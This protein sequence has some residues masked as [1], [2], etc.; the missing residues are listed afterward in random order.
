MVSTSAKNTKVATIFCIIQQLVDCN[1]FPI[2]TRSTLSVRKQ[3]PRK[4]YKRKQHAA[5]LMVGYGLLLENCLTSYWGTGSN[6]Y[7]PPIFNLA[8]AITATSALF[9]HN[10]F[11]FPFSH[12]H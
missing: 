1:W 10:F 12:F 3:K 7:P 9:F 2:P 4:I 8:Q 11:L 5:R 6:N